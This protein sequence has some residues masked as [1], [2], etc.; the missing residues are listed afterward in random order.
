MGL[1]IVVGQLHAQTSLMAGIQRS[2][3]IKNGGQ[4]SGSFE[5][6]HGGSAS[7]GPPSGRR[8][9]VILSLPP[10][11]PLPPPVLLTPTAAVR[12]QAAYSTFLHERRQ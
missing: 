3:W 12:W 5:G 10:P 8:F 11:L 9:K 6:V 2:K 4:T 7:Q 1:Q